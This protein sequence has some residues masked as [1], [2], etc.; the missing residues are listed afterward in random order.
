MVARAV[1]CER[2]RVKYMYTFRHLMRLICAERKKNA[3]PKNQMAG[4]A[5]SEM[6]N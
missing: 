2:F 5:E 4:P 1:H 6:V 3:N